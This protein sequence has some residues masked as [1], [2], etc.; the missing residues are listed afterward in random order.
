MLIIHNWFFS[1]YLEPPIENPYWKLGWGT[2]CYIFFCIKLF[3]QITLNTWRRGFCHLGR[4]KRAGS[5]RCFSSWIPYLKTDSVGHLVLFSVNMNRAEVGHVSQW[6]WNQLKNK[7][8]FILW[9]PAVA[10]LFANSYQVLH[11]FTNMYV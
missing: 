4:F 2:L 3:V 6:P 5:C 8:Q 9:P 10:H 11:S 1:Y 7:T